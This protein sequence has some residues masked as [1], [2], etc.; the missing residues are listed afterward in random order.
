MNWHDYLNTVFPKAL[1]LYAKEHP[2]TSN[3]INHPHCCQ[4]PQARR[5]LFEPAQTRALEPEFSC[6]WYGLTLIDQSLFRYFPENSKTWLTHYP[7]LK[8]PVIWAGMGC[9]QVMPPHYLIANVRSRKIWDSFMNFYAARFE[10]LL[11]PSGVNKTDL[12]AKITNDRDFDTSRPRS[13]EQQLVQALEN[14]PPLAP[15]QTILPLDQ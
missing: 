12:L 14:P 2:D 8:L 4:A 1:S 13:R 9:V 3:C 11:E 7:N 6:M 15:D 10:D 5:V